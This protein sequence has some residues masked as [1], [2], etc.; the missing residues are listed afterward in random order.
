MKKLVFASLVGLGA[1]FAAAPSQAA[2]NRTAAGYE[3]QVKQAPQL[4]WLR[5]QGNDWNQ[6]YPFDHSNPYGPYLPS[7]DGSGR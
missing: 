4:N 1:L 6:S 7:T 3:Q 5:A 2:N